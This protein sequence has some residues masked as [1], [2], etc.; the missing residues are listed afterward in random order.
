MPSDAIG[1]LRCAETLYC[2]I[3]VHSQSEAERIIKIAKVNGYA[4]PRIVVRP[5][6]EGRPN[7]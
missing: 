6:P 3:V 1:L 5:A 2:G 7:A 4:E